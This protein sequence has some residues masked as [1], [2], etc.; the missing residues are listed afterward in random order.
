MIII[1]VDKTDNRV[2]IIDIFVPWDANIESI[3]T[4]RSF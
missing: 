3:S 2:E 4:S 1:M